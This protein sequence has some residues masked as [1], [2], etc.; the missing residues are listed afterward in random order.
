MLHVSRWNTAA[1]QPPT[2]LTARHAPPPPL[3]VCRPSPPRLPLRTLSSPFSRS[4]P[5]SADLASSFTDQTITS[6]ATDAVCRDESAAAAGVPDAVLHGDDASCAPVYLFGV[7]HGEPQTY[8]SRHILSARPAAVVVE[9]ALSPGHGESPGNVISPS[10]SS[11]AEVAADG[12]LRMFSQLA[13][14]IGRA[15]TE[16][17][18]LRLWEAL[19]E[20]SGFAGEQLA[21][22]AA[23]A[24]DADLVY[25]DRPKRTTFERLYCLTTL[26]DLDQAFGL[27]AWYNY[28]EQ[29][30]DGPPDRG[31][32]YRDSV[33]ERIMIHERDAVLCDT[34]RRAAQSA[35]ATRPGSCVVG[36]VG[37]AHVQ[38][39]RQRWQAGGWQRAAP[40]SLTDPDSDTDSCDSAS[41]ALSPAAYEGSEV[42]AGG[43]GGAG[44]VLWAPDPSVVELP[45][46]RDEVSGG[47]RRA[48][49]ESV[50]RLQ[51]DGSVSQDLEQV[52]LRH[53]A[54][55]ALTGQ[56]SCHV[57][58]SP[59]V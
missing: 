6:P 7:E 49:L 23:L 43:G 8:I 4:V 27:A 3:S 14:R 51:C 1:F 10:S 38:G 47:V 42:Q 26:A 39:I 13:Y 50:V 16:A 29:L 36:V 56:A 41:T 45:G 19:E 12:Y 30:S 54:A 15:D 59:G 46:G 48:L 20:G 35:A 44:D 17:E 32:V 24:V 28:L 57:L 25:G 11:W 33:F 58:A 31:Q 40:A 22:V 52:V 53:R 18:R 5:R 2:P 37:A 9:T 34:L 55:V 21:Y